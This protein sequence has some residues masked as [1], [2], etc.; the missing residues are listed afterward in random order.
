MARKVFFSFHYADILNANIVRMSG[1]FKPTAQTGFYLASLWEEAKKKG[2]A[3]VKRLID[4]GLNNTTVT[5]FL[6]GGK[7][8]SRRWCVY[9]RDKSTEDGKGLLGIQLPN[10]RTTGLNTWLTEKG[11]PVYK[12]NPERFAAW[13]EAAAMKAVRRL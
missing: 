5:V 13:V 2:D 4:Q 9:E 1:E 8:Y 12:W 6:V 7:T 11:I 10:E 3:A